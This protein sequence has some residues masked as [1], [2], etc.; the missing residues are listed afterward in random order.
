MKILFYF[1]HFSPK[2]WLEWRRGQFSSASE[3]E[4]KRLR[5]QTLLQRVSSKTRG[6]G[7]ERR[8]SPNSRE[9]PRK[10]VAGSP[11]EERTGQPGAAQKSTNTRND[12]L[13]LALW[14]HCGPWT[15]MSPWQDG[16]G[17]RVRK[18]GTGRTGMHTC[19]QG[20]GETG[21]IGWRQKM[22]KRPSEC[23]DVETGACQ[24]PPAGILWGRKAKE[25]CGDKVKYMDLFIL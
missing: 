2:D 19:R 20:E 10:S 9:K 23:W 25:H 24:K 22:V 16:T 21:C 1:W 15:A 3:W 12:I 8:K 4:Q 14:S 5:C 17:R 7:R 6:M 11:E 13:V 18:W